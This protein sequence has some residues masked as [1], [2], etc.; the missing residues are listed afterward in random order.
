M[1]EKEFSMKAPLANILSGQ[2]FEGNMS[3]KERDIRRDR[4]IVKVTEMLEALGY[5]VTNDPNMKDTPRRFV[6]VLMDEIGKGT[7]QE[8]PK[9][10]VFDNQCDYDGIVFE[11]NIEVKS[12]CSHHLAFIKGYCHI[13]YIPGK[14]VVGL[15]KLNRVVD[16]FAR[17]PQLQEQ[18][19][20]QIHNYLNE[21]LVGNKGVAV[22]I[23]AQHSCVQ[24]R[25]VE[26]KDSFT[27]TCKLSGAFLDNFDKSRDEFY[28]MI[29]N[30]G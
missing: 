7:Y 8:P 21:V 13:A 15:S 17:R 12:L 16:W 18:M 22:L 19:T 11:G 29:R 3:E 28:R 24:M 23:E 30:E 27:T 26:N 4:A 6:K 10:T 5:D 9:I 2:S 20:M 1:I 14:K 25:G